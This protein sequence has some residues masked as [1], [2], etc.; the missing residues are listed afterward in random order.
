MCPAYDAPDL[1]V[2]LN[3]GV[4]LMVGAHDGD[5]GEKSDFIGVSMM[6]NLAYAWW[7]AKEMIK[8]VICEEVSFRRCEM[9]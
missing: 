5:G 8:L 4:L 1:G 6:T 7:F 2:E 3:V 9:M